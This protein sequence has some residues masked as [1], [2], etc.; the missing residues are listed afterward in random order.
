MTAGSLNM[1]HSHWAMDESQ[2]EVQDHQDHSML[3]INKKHLGLNAAAKQN[4][5]NRI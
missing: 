4:I 2:G 3:Q 5:L 1:P